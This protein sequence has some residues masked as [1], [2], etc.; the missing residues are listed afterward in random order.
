M[1]P[2]KFFQ[3]DSSNLLNTQLQLGGYRPNR[4]SQL[5]QQFSLF[6]KQLLAAS[7]LLFLA[8]SASA[9]QIGDVFVI[10]MENHNFTQ[11]NPTSSPQQIFGNSAAPYINNLVAP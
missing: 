10:A 2:H 5:F 11:P 1:A 3:H 4:P 6:P 7:C 9:Q 8:H